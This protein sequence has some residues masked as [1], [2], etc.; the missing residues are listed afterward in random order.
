M[1]KVLELQK[2]AHDADGETI[3]ILKS[4]VSLFVCK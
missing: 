4:S 2:L 1:N 3:G